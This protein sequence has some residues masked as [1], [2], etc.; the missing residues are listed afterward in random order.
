MTDS[1]TSAEI[2][3]R[4]EELK[5]ELAQAERLDG[6]FSEAH[7]ALEAIQ[8]HTLVDDE[9]AAKVELLGAMLGNIHH[10]DADHNRRVHYEQEHF[11]RVLWQKEREAEADDYAENASSK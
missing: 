4:L 10:H 9:T 1:L 11:R 6:Y 7:V 2:E 8:D 3:D 5:S